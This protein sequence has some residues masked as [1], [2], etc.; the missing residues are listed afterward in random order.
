LPTLAKDFGIGVSPAAVV[1]APGNG[2]PLVVDPEVARANVHHQDAA[3]AQGQGQ[4]AAPAAVNQRVSADK[5]SNTIIDPGRPE[6]G[7]D[8]FANGEG[9]VQSGTVLPPAHK[10]GVDEEVKVISSVLVIAQNEEE[11]RKE[12]GRGFTVAMDLNGGMG[13]APNRPKEIRKPENDAE[14]P[15]GESKIWTEEQ[16]SE[17]VLATAAAAEAEA[18]ATGLEFPMGPHDEAGE[19]REKVAE[20][21]FG[22]D[23]DE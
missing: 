11:G 23:V 6:P 22:D 9:E 18:A 8:I 15:E 19:V 14:S 2:G 7:R 3:D 1:P 12:D 21:L 20:E 4:V 13:T 17:E 5:N 16:P 10:A